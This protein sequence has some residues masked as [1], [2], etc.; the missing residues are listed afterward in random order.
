M[1][2]MK[3]QEPIH[4]ILVEALTSHSKCNE[5]NQLVKVKVLSGSS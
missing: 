4:P 3:K 5:V 2:P 1:N